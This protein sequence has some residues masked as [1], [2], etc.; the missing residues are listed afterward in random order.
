MKHM[1]NN[2]QPL[3]LVSI[4]VITYNHAP[5]LRQCLD[6]ILMQEAPSCVPNGTPRCEW[7]ELLIHDD[8]STDGTQDIIREY[9]E[10]YPDVIKPIFETENQY[11]KGG[12]W[13]SAVWGYPYMKGKYWA[14]C[15]GDDA[16][17]DPLKLQ[18][19]V[20]F[21]ELHPEYSICFHCYRNFNIYT[22][23]Y[24]EP[25]A[26]RFVKKYSPL[27]SQPADDPTGCDV[28]IEQ[29]FAH[30]VTMPMSELLRAE[31]FDLQWPY[32]YKYYRDTHE[33]YH[34]LKQGKCRLMNFVGAQRNMH[35]GGM[36]SMV[37]TSKAI[38]TSLLIAQELYDHDYD[39]YTKQYL[40]DTIKWALEHTKPFSCDR[41]KYSARLFV[42][43]PSVM[44]FCK[45][46]VRK[47]YV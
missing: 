27:S 18:K 14:S 29:S 40:I 9:M 41:W 47:G 24:S 4:S 45:N 5:F 22:Q 46:L 1:I 21:M 30:W 20:D 35:S 43:Q 13:G 33:T 12:P 17:T 8:C 32:Q 31:C 39:R 44:G 2:K 23:Q 42:L 38:E 34:L 19:Q 10:Q 3:P 28:T 36:A 15:E 11:S 25:E 37:P 6:G 7:M 16:W 26:T